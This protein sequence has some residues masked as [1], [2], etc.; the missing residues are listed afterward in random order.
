M[1]EIIKNRYKPYRYSINKGITVIDSTSGKYTIKNK[2]Q[3]LFTLF[4]YLDS[5]GFYNH[6]IIDFDNKNDCYVSKYVEEDFIIEDEKEIELAKIVASLHNKTVFFKE[7]S[8]DNYKEIYEIVL[9][10]ISFIHTFY[11]GLFL[12]L[13]KKEF[14]SPSEYL[15][16]RNYYKIV[17]ALSFARDK[18]DLW[19]EGVNK[20]NMRVSIIHN[21]LSIDHFIFNNDKS[22]L[23]SWDKYRIDSPIIDIINLYKSDFENCNF[24]TFL[25]QYLKSFELLDSEKE[26]LLIILSIPLPLKNKFNSELEK[27]KEVKKIVNYIYKIESTIRPYNSKNEIKE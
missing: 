5:K 19:Y 6:P 8:L 20:E 15:L 26:L 1:N 2:T 21:N 27:V 12:N 24:K 25:S 3:D 10:N 17:S 4:N 23:I 7:T 9:E 22:I 16:T 14:Q 18:L 11:E 13:L